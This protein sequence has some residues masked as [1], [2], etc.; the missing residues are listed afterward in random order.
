MSSVESTSNASDA[1]QL[2]K[3]KLQT[4]F[5]TNFNTWFAS[6]KQNPNIKSDETYQTIVAAV[7]QWAN[8]ERF[9]EDMTSYNY[10][11]R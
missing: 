3:E 8:G 5:N 9:K 4:R 2:A 10:G 11:K 7:E 6:K 1:A